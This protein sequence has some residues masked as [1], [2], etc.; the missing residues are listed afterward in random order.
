MSKSRSDKIFSDFLKKGIPWLK[1]AMIAI[2]A[3]LVM[4]SFAPKEAASE[5]SEED[6]IAELC[7]RIDG[8]GDVR[9]MITYTEKNNYFSSTE[10]EVSA[11]AVVCE[12]ADDIVV[13]SKIKKLISSMYGIG[14]N[15]ISV[16]G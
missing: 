13:V 15:R 5:A 6:R 10:R 3:I 14:T 8:V 1:I 9:V 16:I 11:V 4:A 7:S 12:G 2:G